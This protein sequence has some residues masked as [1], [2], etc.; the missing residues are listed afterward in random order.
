MVIFAYNKSVKIFTCSYSDTMPEST[1]TSYAQKPS[2]FYKDTTVVP[3]FDTLTA[4]G[5][6]KQMDAVDYVNKLKA[7]S[8]QKK[9]YPGK[10]KK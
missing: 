4:N 1:D 10:K 2:F 6:F 7:D 9:L 8:L 5:A 3:H